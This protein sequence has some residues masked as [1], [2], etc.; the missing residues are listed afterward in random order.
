MN[1]KDRRRVYLI[2]NFII[3]GIAL[4]VASWLIEAF[5]HT[6]ALS[7]GTTFTDAVF[8]DDP[9]EVW[10]RIFV[11]FLF[12]SF[13]IY[14]QTIITKRRRVED[15]L[16]ESEA[17]Y[18]VLAESAEEAIFIIDRAYSIRYVNR[19]AAGLLD[20]GK[21]EITGRRLDE[22][23]P[24]DI[25][26]FQRERISSVFATGGTVSVED[27]MVFGRHDM[28][29]DTSLVPLRD[30]E[31]KISAVM[32]ISHDITGLKKAE[33]GIAEERDRAQ[34]YLDV[35]GVIL[36]IIG[37]DQGVTL[38]NKKGCELLERGERDILGR[39]WFDNF[40]PEGARAEAV[41][42][43]SRLMS[44]LDGALEY[45][46]GPIIHSG[47]EKTIAWHNTL[48]KD[49]EGKIT[50]ILSSG[51]DITERKLMLEAIGQRLEELER[52]RNATVHREFRMKE[53]KD[54]V[55]E[56][57]GLLARYTGASQTPESGKEKHNGR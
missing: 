15:T 44:G 2:D 34:R 3:I 6:Y 5:I 29:F 43:F 41:D 4:S 31:G 18:S 22:V 48:L 52:F 20:A 10:M 51:E 12:I 23:F 38:I 46:E 11:L 45:Y 53:L 28:W 7:D 30:R 13:S 40:I 25:V 27:R 16:R 49:S 56:L 26:K 39:N 17:L 47:T 50:G 21:D 35:A 24:T 37:K 33:A 8:P 19:F 54:R 32:G 1:N 9:N 55:S 42:V 14:A 57:E 36:I